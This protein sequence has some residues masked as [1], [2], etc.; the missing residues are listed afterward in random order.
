M[1]WAICVFLI[2][3]FLIL[4][5][6]VGIIEISGQPFTVDGIWLGADGENYLAAYSAIL[7]EGVFSPSSTLSYF[8][9]G[10]PILI[11]A[12]SIFGKS[13]VLTTLSIFQSMIFS[14]STYLFA[15]QIL[16]TRLRKFTSIVF[17]LISLNPTLSLSSMVVGYE[18]LTASG[19]LIVIG[20]IIKDCI[21]KNESNF[22]KYL[23]TNSFIIGFLTFVQP[24]LIV[25]GI[26]MNMIWIFSRKVK[27][28]SLFLLIPML[29]ITLLF[30]LALVYRNDQAS[31]LKAISTNLG[32]TMNIGAG[33]NA[34]GGYM[35]E[36]FGVPC[37]PS[38][39]VAQQ[40]NQTV[41]CVLSWYASNPQKTAEL[42]WN[43]SLYFWSPWFNN[44]FL[45]DVNT[46]TMSRNPWLKISPIKNIMDNQNGVD[47]VLGSFGK[48]F[49]WLWLLGG[50]ASMFYGYIIL[51]R[52]NS[53]EK[54]IGNLAIVVVAIN[55]LITLFTIGDHRFRVPIMGL[56]L[57][58]QA[59]GLK[60]LFKGGKAPM[61]DGPSLR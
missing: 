4:N 21:D 51:R 10:Y 17:I 54:F 44:G 46:G 39:T 57:F 8:P 18:S 55:W 2:K 3:L 32:I 11:S 43:K 5:I 60:T 7:R 1:F 61:V 9:A 6:H 49:S 22:I 36:G 33:D 41:K 14:L 12:L 59:V 52:Q 27:K 37:N 34:T 25:S 48:L 56:S 47:L 19:F 50:L 40:D 20:L 26:A 24:R 16:R 15:S 38:G 45:G 29:L 58:L 30:P 23:V 31:G 42:F 35:R 53:L 13:W 28:V